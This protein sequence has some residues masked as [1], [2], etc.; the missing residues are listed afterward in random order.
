M[1]Q[2]L[3]AIVLLLS[4]THGLADL[5]DVVVG[6]GVETAGSRDPLMETEQIG[7]IVKPSTLGFLTT[8]LIVV[9]SYGFCA[10]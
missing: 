9:M 2:C 3:H 8:G 10:V 5:L 1:P 4:H 6:I 7:V